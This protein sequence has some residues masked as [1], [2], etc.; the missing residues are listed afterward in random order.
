M[1]FYNEEEKEEK[2]K[3]KEENGLKAKLDKNCDDHHIIA[4]L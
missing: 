3:D 4:L 2:E 1:I